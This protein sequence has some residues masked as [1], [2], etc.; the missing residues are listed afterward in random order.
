MK[1]RSKIIIVQR[2]HDEQWN[3]IIKKAITSYCT[4]KVAKPRLNPPNK[5]AAFDFLV[6][7]QAS[8]SAS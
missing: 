3:S 1:N 7:I 2:I 8:K 4:A 6:I 5:N